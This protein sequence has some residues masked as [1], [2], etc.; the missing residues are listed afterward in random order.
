MEMKPVEIE[1]SLQTTFNRALDSSAQL[2]T[3][4][5][6]VTHMLIDLSN[7][8]DCGLDLDM[9]LESRVNAD[10]P[11]C[12]PVEL[13]AIYALGTFQWTELEITLLPLVLLG[14]QA[15]ITATLVGQLTRQMTEQ[16]KQGARRYAQ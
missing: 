10:I 5:I 11:E 1:G 9:S 8:F 12:K 7:S 2:P 14:M 3:I 15:E 6:Q 13:L 16:V 4:S